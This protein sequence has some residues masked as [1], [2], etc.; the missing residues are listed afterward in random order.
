[1]DTIIRGR[2][3]YREKKIHVG[4]RPSSSLWDAVPKKQ[5]TRG[6]LWKLVAAVILT[7]FAAVLI[8][9]PQVSHAVRQLLSPPAAAEEP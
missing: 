6:D 9:R 7:V 8:L 1:M 5:E 2:H 4:D 3:G